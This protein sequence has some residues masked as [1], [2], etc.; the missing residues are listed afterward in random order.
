VAASVLNVGAAVVGS[1]TRLRPVRGP[2]P[3]VAGNLVDCA[4]AGPVEEG[5]VTTEILEVG[6][7]AGVQ[8]GMLGMSVKKSGR[9]TGLTTGTIQQVDVTVRVSFGVGRSATF[10][11]QLMAGPMSQGGDSG[12][13]VLDQENRVV[14]LLFAGSVGSTIFNRIQNVFHALQVRLF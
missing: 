1:R 10:T 7:L 2:W 8:E 9:T 3:R 12:S 13:V 4:I 5:A 11:D 14:G 6:S